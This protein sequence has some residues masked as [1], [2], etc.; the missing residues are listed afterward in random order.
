[1]SRGQRRGV[2]ARQARARWNAVLTVKRK[3]LL[4]SGLAT[5]F[6]ASS[7]LPTIWWIEIDI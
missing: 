5:N 2:I 3:E 6:A 1:M 7:S 4:K